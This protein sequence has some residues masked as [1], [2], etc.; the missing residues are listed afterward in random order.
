MAVARRP[1]GGRGKKERVAAH[2]EELKRLIRETHPEARFEIAAVPESRWP[3]LW[4][5]A[6]FD[7][8]WDILDLVGDASADF[9]G[10]ELTGV[11][12][13]PMELNGSDD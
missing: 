4:V 10:E 13:I 6:K 1:R 2:V 12:V 7:S 5:Y 3:G 11:H 9:L 8:L